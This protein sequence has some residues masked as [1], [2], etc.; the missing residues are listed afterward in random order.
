MTKQA[1]TLP[2]SLVESTG[3]EPVASRCQIGTCYQLHHDPILIRPPSK[4]DITEKPFKNEELSVASGITIGSMVNRTNSDL[5]PQGYQTPY[6]KS[7]IIIQQKNSAEGKSLCDT[8]E[9]RNLHGT[10]NL[11]TVSQTLFIKSN[12]SYSK[13]PP[14]ERASVIPSRRAVAVNATALPSFYLSISNS[15]NMSNRK[16]LPF[17]RM[18]TENH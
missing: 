14:F 8:Q 2:K 3:L 11:S 7:S 1:C 6:N 9:S 5:H 18:G 12:Q 10:C 17:Q 16:C 4:S 13:T 15:T